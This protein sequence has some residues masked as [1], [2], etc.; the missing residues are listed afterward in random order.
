MRVIAFA[1]DCKR[2]LKGV[3]EI[4]ETFVGGRGGRSTKLARLTPVMALIEQGGSM[5]AKV[6]GTNSISE[7]IAL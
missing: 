4:D 3:V 2:Q 6:E 5:K 1:D 7:Q